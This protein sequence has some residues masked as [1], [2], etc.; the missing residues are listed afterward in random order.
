MFG[1]ESE[2]LRYRIIELPDDSGTVEVLSFKPRLCKNRKCKH[3]PSGTRQQLGP[4]HTGEKG[5][6]RHCFKR[7]G[8]KKNNG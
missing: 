6:C 1:V 7:V 3:G 2:T 4:K 5:Y 8:R